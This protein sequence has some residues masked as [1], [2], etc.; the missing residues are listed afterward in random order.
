MAKKKKVKPVEVE[1]P[2]Q[3]AKPVEVIKVSNGVTTADILDVDLEQ[4]EKA[5]WKK[6]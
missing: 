3:E 1:T 2:Q 5:G 6:V 4:M